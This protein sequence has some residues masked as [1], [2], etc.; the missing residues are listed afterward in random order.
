MLP[1]GSKAQSKK[2][3]A[4]SSSG[5]KGGQT[6]KPKE[7]DSKKPKKTKEQK[8]SNNNKGKCFHCNDQGHW[9]RKCPTYLAELAEKKKNGVTDL[10]VLDEFNAEDHSST[11]IVDSGATNHVCSSLQ[12][13]SSW[14]ELENG[15]LTLKVDNKESITAK[16][17]GEARLTFENKILVL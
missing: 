8:Q 7:K 10:H 1:K 4:S 2:R 16:A 11:W 17:V 13:F 12:L 6:S 5:T 15:D 9:R 3:Q 14:R